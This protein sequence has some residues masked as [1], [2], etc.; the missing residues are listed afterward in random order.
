MSTIEYI[1]V[2]LY[3]LAPVVSSLGYLPQLR[4][5]L[6]SA[7]HE[8]KGI[9]LQAWTLWLGNSLVALAYG[10]IRLHDTL[11]ITVC[12]ISTFWCALLI[13]LTLWKRAQGDRVVAVDQ[14]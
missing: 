4:K 10:V 14:I 1:V 9:S 8:L 6:R 5:V 7:P 12:S 2:F 13:S 3:A 11:F